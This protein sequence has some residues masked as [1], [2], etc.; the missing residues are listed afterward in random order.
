MAQVLKDEIRERIFNAAIDA[1]Y[2]KDYKSAS[3]QE[4]AK[5]AKVP[6]GL[7]YSYYKNKEE[8]FEKI[9]QPILWQYPETLKKASDTH[10]F[11]LNVYTDIEKPFY[12]ELFKR[13]RQFVILMDKSDGTKFSDSKENMINHLETHIHENWKEKLGP[14]Y[15]D[16]FIHI[17]SKSHIEGIIEI[18]RNYKDQEWAMKLLDLLTL[19]AF[20]GRKYL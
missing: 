5:R 20:N 16:L 12:S 9:V 19:Y 10:T 8:I 17:I 14:E 1:F 2:E 18:A 6:V 13:H 11:E 7:I 3:M 4:I 15:D